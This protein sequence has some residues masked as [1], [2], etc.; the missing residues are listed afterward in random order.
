MRYSTERRGRK[1]VKGYGF[2]SFTR[3]LTQ[4]AAAKKA[5]DSLVKHGTDAAAKAAKRAVNKAAEATGDLVGQK[6][7]D[8]IVKKA[9]VPAKEFSPEEKQRILE[10]LALL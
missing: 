9:P 3:G 6:I 1:Y 7:A 2:L 10:E 5:R 8:K 4:S